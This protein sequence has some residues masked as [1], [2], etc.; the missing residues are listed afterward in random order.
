M[1][2]FA[3]M[4]IL[5]AFSALAFGPYIDAPRSRYDMLFISDALHDAIAELRQSDAPNAPPLVRHEKLWRG[6][7]YR[8]P[9]PLLDPWLFGGVLALFLLFGALGLISANRRAQSARLLAGLAAILAF[10]GG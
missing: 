8:D 3:Q 1:Q 7:E 5:G 6:E 10:V 4:P 2:G 9:A